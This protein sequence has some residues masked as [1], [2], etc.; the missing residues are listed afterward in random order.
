MSVLAEAMAASWAST[1]A[2]RLHVLNGG[3]DLA[4]GHVIALFDVEVGDAAKGGG[5]DIDVGLGLDL[6][7]AA[8]DGGEILAHDFGRQYL[9]VTG[10]LMI[11]EPDEKPTGR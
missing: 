5:A 4:L 9:G 10:L 11:D 3:Q 8:D 2:S 1:L 6:A 7:G